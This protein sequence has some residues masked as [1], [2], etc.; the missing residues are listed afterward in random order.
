MHADD[1]VRTCSF[2]FSAR[3]ADAVGRE[4]E[5]DDKPKENDQVEIRRNALGSQG[6]SFLPTV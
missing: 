5:E 2:C 6:I 4:Q 1:S 3:K